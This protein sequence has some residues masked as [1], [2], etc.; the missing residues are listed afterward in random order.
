MRIAHVSD[1]HVSRYG[2]VYEERKS[3]LKEATGSGW[4]TL[5]DDGDGWRV[6]IQSA[7]ERTFVFR[8][9]LRLVDDDGLVHQIVRARPEDRA[10]KQEEL[11]RIHA[12]KKSTHSEILAR[13]FPSHD[14]AAEMLAADPDNANLRF[15]LL[16]HRVRQLEPDWVVITGDLTEDAVG[17][18]LVS[19]GFRP[20]I[21]RQRF[22]AIPG[23]H[24]IYPSMPFVVAKPFRKTEGQKRKIW[25]TWAASVGVPS[26]GSFLKELGDGVLLVALDSCHPP[27]IPHSA[28]GLVELNDLHHLRGELDH[29]SK[30]ETRI[31]CLHHHIVNPPITLTGAAPLQAGMRLRNAKDVVDELQSLG[32]GLILNGHR[33]MG[34]RYHPARSPLFLSSPSSTLGCRTGLG[35]YFWLIDVVGGQE[36]VIRDV[37]VDDLEPVYRS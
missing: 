36:P 16:A 29:R 21:E 20:F 23:N 10:A 2:N 34:Y 18:E 37:H 6:E 31:A 27:K 33:H 22:L 19:A 35:P 5:S 9:N 11:A 7:A 1:F 3:P 26:G 28:S 14:R 12:R 32:L 8:D 15:C 24:D 13:D 4:E 25:S 30:Q 17:F